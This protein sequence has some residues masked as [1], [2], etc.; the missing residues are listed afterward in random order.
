[1][2][3]LWLSRGVKAFLIAKFYDFV[4]VARRWKDHTYFFPLQLKMSQYVF[5]SFPLVN[6]QRWILFIF[7]YFESI[8][9]LP[10]L[11]IDSTNNG[12][13]FNVVCFKN[14]K[15]VIKVL[16]ILFFKDSFFPFFSEGEGGGGVKRAY[17]WTEITT[18]KC[19]YIA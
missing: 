7:L 6:A 9:L 1:M 17:C 4:T 19:K 8:F 2:T 15:Q 13:F 5:F 11:Q 12:V 10:E 18:N 3:F 14:I 16:K